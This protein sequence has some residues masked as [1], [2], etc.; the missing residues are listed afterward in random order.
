MEHY[1]T[2]ALSVENLE[3]IYAQGTSRLHALKNLSFTLHKGEVLAL[4][5]ESGSGKSTCGKAMLGLLPASAHIRSGTLRLGEA[6]AIDLS[7]PAFKWAHLRGKRIAMIYQD[8]QLAL[9]PTKTI[10]SHF[11]ETMLFHHLGPSAAIEE[12]SRGILGLLG[13]RDPA[14]ILEA[15]PF[16][17]SGGMCQ[18]VYIALALCL[19]PEV[20]IA[21]EPT[22]A[23]DVVSQREVLKLLKQIQREF[24]LAILLI[25]HDIGVAYEA[26]D[27]VMVLEQG[28]VIEEGPTSQ[29]LLHPQKCYT[30]ALIAA[31]ALSLAPC[32]EEVCRED[33]LLQIK[34]LSKTYGKRA[35]QIH[36]LNEFSLDLHKKDVIGILGFSGC[37]KSTLAKCITGLETA[38]TGRIFYHGVDITHLRGRKRRWVCKSLQ[39]VFQDARASLNPRRSAL[40][41][42]QEPLNYLGLGSRKERKEKAQYYLNKVGIDSA[43]QN[44]RPPQLSTGQCQRIAI[45]RALVVEPDILICDE[46]VSALDMILQK[47]I[48]NLLQ[49]L[50]QIWGFALVMISH[51]IRV[52]RNLCRMVTIMKDGKLV[53]FLPSSHLEKSESSYTKALIASELHLD[54]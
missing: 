1:T 25:T 31:R 48:L 10:R 37:G 24:S 23:L 15:Y 19:N 45:A 54:M 30:Q 38:D 6:S 2:P 39:I 27:R 13:F 16:E 26:S 14:R 35:S 29:V 8:A 12:K 47:Q 33:I 50:Q 36:A 42:V 4:L 3:V 44:R 17:L 40:Q 32:P 18:R 9:N 41:L 22:S 11:Q 21:D 51:D 52:V 43:T 46:A 34:Q 5:G 20:L 7:E 53:E 28:A 49:E